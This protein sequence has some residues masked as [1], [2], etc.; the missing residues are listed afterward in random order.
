LVLVVPRAVVGRRAGTAWFTTIGDGPGPLVSG[1]LSRG[2]L[3]TVSRETAPAE[4]T[5]QDGSLTAFQWEHAVAEAVTRIR[6]GDL[7]KVVLARDQRATAAQPIDQRV[8]LRRLASRYAGCYTF[9]C[10]G[11]VGATPELV[12]WRD[13][14]QISSLVLAGTAPAD[15]A[16][17]RTPRSGLP[18]SPR[19]RT[20][21]A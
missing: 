16:R 8:L 6:A 11:L 7:S 9:A 10:A 1:Q 13:G 14:Q 5:W 3:S 2:K 21:G 18:C 12:I 15:R 17:P 19:P 4:V 20:S